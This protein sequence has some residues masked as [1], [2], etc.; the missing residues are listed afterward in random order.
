M[1]EELIVIALLF[2]VGLAVLL[3][4]MSKLGC[5]ESSRDF[6]EKTVPHEDDSS[7]CW[8]TPIPPQPKENSQ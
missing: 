6:A 1:R 3:G 2:A 5:N 7:W 8:E 4:A